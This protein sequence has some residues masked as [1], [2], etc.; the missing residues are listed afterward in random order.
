MMPA[1]RGEKSSCSDVLPYQEQTER[2]LQN[3]FSTNQQKLYA[4]LK[5]DKVTELE[6]IIQGY[7]EFA[8]STNVEHATTFLQRQFEQAAQDTGKIK[9]K[10]KGKSTDKVWQV[11]FGKLP[12]VNSPVIIKFH[13]PDPRKP[14]S[15]S[16]P[17]TGDIESGHISERTSRNTATG[18]PH[19]S[20]PFLIEHFPEST[21]KRPMGAVRPPITESVVNPQDS[22]YY[23]PVIAQSSP[24][25]K[26]TPREG[27]DYLQIN[28]AYMACSERS[29]D[30]H[31]PCTPCTPSGSTGVTKT[32]STKSASPLLTAK[33]ISHL[34][35]NENHSFPQ[36]ASSTEKTASGLDKKLLSSLG[37]KSRDNPLLGFTT[38]FVGGE[39]Y[40]ETSDGK[41]F[42]EKNSGRGKD[43]EYSN[44]LVDT[45]YFMARC[46][47]H[48]EQFKRKS[49]SNVKRST[50]EEQCNLSKLDD[51]FK[52]SLKLE[53]GSNHKVTTHA[54]FKIIEGEPL[55][56]GVSKK[57]ATAPLLPTTPIKIELD[58]KCKAG[59]G[60]Q[61]IMY[62]GRKFVHNINKYYQ[63]TLSDGTEL[64]INLKGNLYKKSTSQ[65]G[66]RICS[67]FDPNTSRIV[68]LAG[69]LYSEEEAF[70]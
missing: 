48:S 26:L 60:I 18:D 50:S 19:I 2:L 59:T 62:Q 64:F 44:I 23:E 66:Y 42:F 9:S 10:R 17:L 3:Y 22:S 11:T 35:I 36:Q 61:Y 43:K 68:C 15:Y 63:H 54:H 70:S 39:S 32:L 28:P 8:R 27:P 57:T 4:A 65:D 13:Y 34:K 31:S 20:N 53:E 14:K 45:E 38:Y 30:H 49:S 52:K 58:I 47:E 51:T 40:K 55:A 6:D 46:L 21:Y 56:Q 25:Q 29:P 16:I 33:P 12:G 37:I 69:Q 5:N 1:A 41:L 7:F 67:L 24:K